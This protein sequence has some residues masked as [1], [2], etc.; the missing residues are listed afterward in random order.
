MAFMPWNDGLTLGIKS[1][2]DQHHELVDRINALNEQLGN[3]KA[4]GPLLE[5]L[6][7]AAVNH[8]IAE[9]ELLKRHGYAQADAH[10]LAHSGETSKLVA[11]IDQVHVDAAAF[12]RAH[13]AALKD[14]L[15]QHIQVDD[16]ACVALL[17]S[18]GE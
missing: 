8:F 10:A 1:I 2:D 7:D 16:Q 3:P 4:A 12:Q 6:V 14:W 17:K 11:L 13:L 18:K 5:D 15:T 9:E